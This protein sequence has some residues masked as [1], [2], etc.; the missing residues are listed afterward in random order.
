MPTTSRLTH[1][2]LA[3]KVND[4]LTSSRDAV[5]VRSNLLTALDL[6]ANFGVDHLLD[7]AQQDTHRTPCTALHIELGQSSYL[8]ATL[9][10]ATA[11]FERLGCAIFHDP[12]LTPSCAR[13]VGT[14][15][16]VARARSCWT[17]LLDYGHHLVQA[18]W[19]PANGQLAEFQHE[20]F[21]RY[22]ERVA[23]MVE[24]VEETT[25]TTR[26]TE[27]A[28]DTRTVA[29][30]REDKE[31]HVELT[32]LDALP[33]WPGCACYSTADTTVRGQRA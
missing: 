26:A 3:V 24:V 14:A 27:A 13:A 6:V 20:V 2:Q 30:L 7:G 8:D 5:I 16:D 25:W 11:I 32:R 10:L 17:E 18:A 19:H 4:L 23:E 22:V 12:V 15:I 21:A 28:V 31:L 33:S 29:Q 1:D 9:D